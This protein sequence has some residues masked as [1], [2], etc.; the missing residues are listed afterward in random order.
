MVKTNTDKT[1]EQTERKTSAGS[2]LSIPETQNSMST[3][4][5]CIILAVLSFVLYA[6]TLR[7][8]YALDDSA[9]IVKNTLV[10]G[11]IKNISQLLLTSRMAGVGVSQ[12][13][14]YRPLSLI[15]F[16]VEHDL[17]GE[18][19]AAGHFLNVLFF[20]GCVV[21]LFLF[22]D[23]LFEGRKTM[24]SFTAAILFLLHP[25]HTEVVA[26]IKSRDEIMCFFF[27]F[28]ALRFFL[29]YMRKGKWHSIL[30]SALSLFLSYLSKE[31]VIT[32][33]FVIPLIFFFLRRDNSKRA[34]VISGITGAV[35]IIYLVIRARALSGQGVG[36]GTVAFM[37][38]A[39][40]NADTANRVATAILVLG[41]YLV[42]LFIPYPLSCDYCYNSI[43]ISGFSNAWVLLSLA[44]YISLICFSIKL[45][46]SDR[47]SPWAFGILFFL[48]TLSLV[49]NI[50]FVI[51]SEM[52][53]RFLFFPSVGFCLVVALAVEKWLFIPDQPFKATLSR[54]KVLA[55]LLPV[56]LLFAWLTI[57]RNNDWKDNYTLFKTD[58]E[59]MPG[60]AKLNYFLGNELIVNK[61]PDTQ[62]KEEQKQIFFDAVKYLQQALNIYP[63]Y[64][65]A[66]TEIG[67]AFFSVSIYDSALRHFNMALGLDP[68]QYTAS[69]NSAVIYMRTGKFADAISA[70]KKTIAVLPTNAQAYYDMGGCYI[71]LK[72]YDSAISVLQKA[73]VADPQLTDAYMQLGLANF[74]DKK[75]DEAEKW[76]KKVVEL[77]PGNIPALGNLGTIYLTDGKL[78]DALT[79]FKKAL[80]LDPKSAI[81]Y[82]NLGHCYFKMKQ[83][84]EAI[85]ALAKAVSMNS[86][87]DKDVPCI[88]LSYKALGKLEQAMQ[89]ESLAKKYHPDFS[90]QSG[91][92]DY[93]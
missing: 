82:S 43:P 93:Q 91:E 90:L 74:L 3:N 30:L 63:G 14:G 60:N 13:D 58:V 71:Q 92:T 87:N 46:V 5:L 25:I 19:P 72:N 79:I 59:K 68:K 17:F 81:G 15:M 36:A 11:G 49:S 69:N 51:G 6:N 70:Y 29:I 75:Y 83:Y 80:A 18:N 62:D 34:I 32:F 89:Y 16:A 23:K 45:L 52:G 33:L 47:K 84:N 66:H 8:G 67:N 31:T 54:G 53:E 64:A 26:N 73:I 27:A 2:T 57:A 7:N 4:K 28:L 86:K 77:Q 35:T 41:K 9:M 50:P 12:S 44:A 10:N 48:A 22:L 40:V 55:V 38:N 39:L 21:L 56:C 24:V 61:F 42:L 78:E 20:A 1:T 37:D 76:I 85:D 88:A 65:D